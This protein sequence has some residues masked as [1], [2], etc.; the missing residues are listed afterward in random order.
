M[1]GGVIVNVCGIL[2]DQ[3]KTSGTPCYLPEG[4]WD[5]LT[6]KMAMRRYHYGLRK[7]HPMS[8]I[9]DIA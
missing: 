3:E 2:R 8:L 1:A 5:L 4:Y 7:K 9:Q 6:R